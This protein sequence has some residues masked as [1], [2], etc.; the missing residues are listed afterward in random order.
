MA[1]CLDTLITT[2]CQRVDHDPGRLLDVL[3]VV[4]SQAYCISDEAIDIIAEELGIPR[5]RVEGAVTFYAFFSKAPKGQIAIRL[6]S[7]IIDKLHGADEVAEALE[8]KLGIRF[9][10]T[11]DDGKFSL[12]WTSCIGMC[13]QAPAALVNDVVITRLTP[14]SARE[15]IDTLRKDADPAKL[16]VKPGEGNNAHPLVRAMVNNN[17][18][19][20]ESKSVVLGPVNRGEAIRKSL[21]MTPTEVIRALKTSR[22]RGRGGAGFPCG[23]KWEFARAAEGARKFIICN[24][25]EGDPGTFKDRILLTEL[26]DRIFAGM[27]IA[28]YAIGAEEGIVYLRAEYAYLQRMLEE[29]LS[30]RRAD[31][32][33]GEN[34]AGKKGYHF[35]IRI[36][37]GAGAYICGEETALI[38]SAEGTRGDPKNRPPFP[39]QQG[40]LGCPTIINNCE[41][42]CCVA[43][44]LEQGAGTFSELGTEQSSGTKVLSISGD[45]AR[46]GVYEV[47]FGTSLRKVLQMAGAKQTQAVQVGGPSGQLIGPDSFDRLICFDDLATGGSMMVFDKSRN[48]LE[49]VH[50]FMEFF[51]EESCGYCTPCRVGNVLLADG[52]QRVLEGRGE[53]TDLDQFQQIGQMMK[54][55][56][57]CGLGQTSWRPV[58]TSLE[59]FPHLYEAL[60]KEDSNGFQR[61]FDLLQ[62]IT[63]AQQI[64]GRK[65]SLV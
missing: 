32:W 10:E 47:E 64:T 20:K 18:Y 30:Q 36:Q 7:D 24:A 34:I 8:S 55:C 15:V 5:V 54:A 61:S 22:L 37:L 57:R 45:C 39:A 62:E 48:L 1:V 41:T 52:I 31:G 27:T 42:L 56:S 59:N 50:A 28:G 6:S 65:S 44:I 63:D 9:G 16:V 29:N 33:L 13:D 2:A 51:V 46:P 14:E 53:P 38:S 43:K 17:I 12:D 3:H 26:A 40:Y 19:L 21:G 11:T 35:D 25:D 58:A 49:I 4:Q 60:V 23:M